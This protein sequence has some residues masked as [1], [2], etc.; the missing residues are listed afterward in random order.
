LVVFATDGA[1][2]D[3]Y[4]WKK[5]GS[6]TRYAEVRHAEA[7]GAL[8]EVGVSRFIF[9][10]IEDQTLYRN[11]SPAIAA[12]RALARDFR[13]QALLT[14]T[15]EGGHPDHD[16]CAFIGAVIGSALALPVW[17][18]PLYQRSQGKGSSL[19]TFISGEPDLALSPSEE[20]LGRKRR[21][22][23]RYA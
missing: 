15:Y 11:L 7:K 22:I 14:H 6:R 19:Q 2:R 4:F 23:A 12:L 9:L 18:M 10:D 8:D 17:E 3:E 1:P 20:E 5:F 21:M 16:A 13:P